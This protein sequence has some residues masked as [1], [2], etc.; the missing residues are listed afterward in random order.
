MSFDTPIHELVLELIDHGLPVNVIADKLE[1]SYE[2]IA[3]AIHRKVPHHIY[4]RFVPKPVK[5]GSKRRS[6]SP[7]RDPRKRPMKVWWEEQDCPKSTYRTFCKRVARGESMEAAIRV[8]PKTEKPLAHLW[9][10]HPNPAVSLGTFLTR[11]SRGMDVQ[12]ALERETHMTK[13]PRIDGMAISR[14]YAEFTGSPA[15]CLEVFQRRILEGMDPTEAITTPALHGF[16]AY[17]RGPSN[18]LHALYRVWVASGKKITYRRALQKYRDGASLEEAVTPD[19]PRDPFF[20]EKS[21]R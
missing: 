6:T 11:V 21:D 12:E 17:K 19:R 1:M 15:C 9:R 20:H 18:T 13:L 5:E 16:R 4:K 8:L 2:E 14:W 10:E 3:T 7:T